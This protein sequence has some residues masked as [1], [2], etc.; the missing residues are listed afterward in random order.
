MHPVPNTSGEGHA[1]VGGGSQ[2]QR[3]VK[4]RNRLGMHAR[5][6]VKFVQLA[7]HFESDIHVIKDDTPVNGKSIMGLLT[8]VAALGTEV[9]VSASGA[10]AE[11]AVDALV[12]LVDNG[13][14][15]GVADA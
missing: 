14:G 1:E 9:I 8:L 3:S 13:F 10:D 6:A 7:N 5:A 15:E 11:Q 4:I 12:A 2:T